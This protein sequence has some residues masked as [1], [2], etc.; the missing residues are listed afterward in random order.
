MGLSCIP[1]RK[2][3]EG[4]VIRNPKALKDVMF[5]YSNYEM[6]KYIGNSVRGLAATLGRT[7]RTCSKKTKSLRISDDNYFCLFPL[8][9]T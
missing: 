9:Y 1:K 5:C 7:I 6:D 4:I 3:T 2:E 8:R